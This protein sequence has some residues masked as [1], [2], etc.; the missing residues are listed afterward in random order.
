MIDIFVF[1]LSVQK[2]LKEKKRSK[3]QRQQGEAY[4]D[5]VDGR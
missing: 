5:G 3:G 4:P 1:S 2:N